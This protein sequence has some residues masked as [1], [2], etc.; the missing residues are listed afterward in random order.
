MIPTFKLNKYTS[1]LLLTMFLSLPLFVAVPI[2]ASVDPVA[3]A[4]AAG[5]EDFQNAPETS[6][7]LSYLDDSLENKGSSEIKNPDITR[8]VVIGLLKAQ[9]AQKEYFWDGLYFKTFDID[10]DGDEEII[11]KID[12]AVHLGEF[13]IFDRQMDGQYRLVAEEPWKVESF[14][15]LTP[16]EVGRKKIYEVVQ[17]DGGTGL[18]VFTAHLVY[19]EKGVLHKVWQGTLMERVA[20]WPHE[21]RL[22]VGG[23]RYDS[24]SQNLY[25]WK[26]SL[27]MDQ[28]G[29]DII[30]GS[31]QSTFE[32]LHFNGSIFTK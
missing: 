25:V 17:R 10:G 12:G 4:E 26:T 16:I 21:N 20:M 31:G 13:F 18:D 5:I 3:Q 30:E 28:N 8:D 15:D 14:N 23:Y 9:G 6:Q 7:R 32:M 22:T 29:E 19:F 1:T 27:P 2:A 24:L 11:A